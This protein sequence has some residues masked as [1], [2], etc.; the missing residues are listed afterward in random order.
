MRSRASL[1]GSEGLQAIRPGPWHMTTLQ[2][3]SSS[4][5]ASKETYKG[6]GDV[7]AYPM[8]TVRSD[9]IHERRRWGVRIDARR[10][11]AIWASHLAK[12]AADPSKDGQEPVFVLPEVAAV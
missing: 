7:G 11:W 3:R 8:E 5:T 6:L 1:A 2:G 12:D 4:I 9:G 10:E